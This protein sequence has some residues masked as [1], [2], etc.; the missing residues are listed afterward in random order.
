MNKQQ[1]L[2][3]LDFLDGRGMIFTDQELV[4]QALTEY[5]IKD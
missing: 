1:V 2:D 4:E 3:L 5:G